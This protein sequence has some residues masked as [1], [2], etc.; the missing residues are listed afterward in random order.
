MEGLRIVVTF[1]IIPIYPNISHL[2]L[3]LDL[4]FEKQQA[5]IKIVIDDF[6]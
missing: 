6:V 4:Y 1:G 3:Y 2:K 5:S